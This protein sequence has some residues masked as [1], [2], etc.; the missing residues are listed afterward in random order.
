MHRDDLKALDEIKALQDIVGDLGTQASYLATAEALLPVD[1]A[2]IGKMKSTREDVLK[3]VT[4]AGKRS[5]ASVRQQLARKLA[6]LKKDYVQV[7]L[8]LHSRTRL[9]VSEDKRKA[10]LMQDNRLKTL[11]KLSTI[12][13]MP[14]QHLTDFQNRLAGLKSCF[15]LTGGDLETSA[16]CPHCGFKPD[17]EQKGA[18]G[19]DVL[20][21]LDTELDELIGD[22]TQTLLANLD[23]PT[24]K[25]NLGLLK[26]EARKLINTF[27]GDKGLPEEPIAGLHPGV[28][29][30]VVRP[31]QSIG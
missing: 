3:D 6:N 4:D 30:S 10:A 15:A 7:Y 21:M 29:G 14:V 24:T 27:I 11:Q 16:T 2:W 12:D 22:W 28:E 13:L 25:S 19:S 18:P 9:G 26:D 20:N 8:K 1:H 31:D 17:A 5:Q 23:D